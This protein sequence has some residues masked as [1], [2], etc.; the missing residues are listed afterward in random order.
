MSRLIFLVFVL[1]LRSGA[2]LNSVLYQG[3]SNKL[4]VLK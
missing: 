2:R 1:K 4:H 3:G